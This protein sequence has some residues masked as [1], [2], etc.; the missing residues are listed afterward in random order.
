METL[1]SILSALKGLE[2]I[3]D[4]FFTHDLFKSAWNFGYAEGYYNLLKELLTSDRARDYITDENIRD[5]IMDLQNRIKE[6]QDSLL[7]ALKEIEKR[8]K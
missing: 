6:A 2:T 7:K 4:Q 3:K 5:I 1:N 8:E